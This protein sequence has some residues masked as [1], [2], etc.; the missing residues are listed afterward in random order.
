M[1][2][3]LGTRVNAV[4]PGYIETPVISFL[5][6]TD[7]ESFL[8]HVALKRSVKPQ[9]IAEVIAFLAS[10]KSSYVNGAFIYVYGGML[11]G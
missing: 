8:N 7:I 4:L 1:L 9:E 11:V 2:Y 3:K 6:D 5:S 10:D